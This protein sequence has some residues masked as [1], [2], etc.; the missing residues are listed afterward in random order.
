[1]EHCRENPKKAIWKAIPLCIL[2]SLWLE[3]NHRGLEKVDHF[4]ME[5]KCQSLRCL[6]TTTLFRF[7]LYIYVCL[8]VASLNHPLEIFWV[9]LFVTHKFK[10]KI[11]KWRKTSDSSFK[12][13]GPLPS[14]VYSLLKSHLCQTAPVN[15]SCKKKQTSMLWF[16]IF[17]L[18]PHMFQST[19]FFDC[20]LKT[21]PTPT[22]L[23]S[24]LIIYI[25]MLQKH[26]GSYHYLP[27]KKKK[28]EKYKFEKLR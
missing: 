14:T 13:K 20:L 6:N 17:Q 8:Y 7:I 22:F 23:A 15:S 9:D 21:L 24:T 1:M 12:T 3:R 26:F 18:L 25:S 28:K 5:F 16:D 2:W 11:R 10:N 4:L 19:T 27:N